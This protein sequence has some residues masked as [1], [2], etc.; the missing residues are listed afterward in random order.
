MSVPASTSAMQSAKL[1]HFSPSWVTPLISL[2]WAM[3]SSSAMAVAKAMI[4]HRVVGLSG[5]V[6]VLEVRGRLAH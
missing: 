3:P 1:V 6:E 5:I 2:A 4:V